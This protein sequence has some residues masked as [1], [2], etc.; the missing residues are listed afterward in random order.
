MPL[1][2]TTRSGFS[3]LS[4]ISLC[5][6]RTVDCLHL[7][8]EEKLRKHTKAGFWKSLG[9]RFTWTWNGRWR[10]IGIPGRTRGRCW[11]TARLLEPG[12]TKRSC[13]R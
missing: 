6:Q 8:S 10:D 3:L 7:R 1:R 13:K 9:K 5:V 2:P 12:G 11:W 4:V